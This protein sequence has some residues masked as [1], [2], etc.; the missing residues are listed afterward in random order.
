MQNCLIEQWM[1]GMWSTIRRNLFFQT[2]ESNFDLSSNAKKDGE[3]QTSLELGVGSPYGWGI[4]YQ[5]RPRSRLDTY[6]NSIKTSGNV[7][8]KY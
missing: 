3:M 4:L 2:V 6:L 5:D 1:V 8:M 7:E